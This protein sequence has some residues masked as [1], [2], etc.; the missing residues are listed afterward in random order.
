MKYLEA[1]KKRLKVNLIETREKSK[2]EKTKM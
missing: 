1:F 2:K